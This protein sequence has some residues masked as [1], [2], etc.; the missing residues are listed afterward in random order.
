MSAES[1]VQTAF[2]SRKTP[3]VRLAYNLREIVLSNFNGTD[4][5]ERPCDMHLEIR[6]TRAS[7]F[8]HI[9]H[10]KAPYDWK[11]LQERRREGD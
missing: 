6:K 11:S 7:H 8:G 3:S 5:K 10:L 2:F 9:N 1:D 4:V